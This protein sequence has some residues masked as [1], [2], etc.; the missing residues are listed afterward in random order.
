MPKSTYMYWNNRLDLPDKDLELRD[1]ILKI[2]EKHPCYGYRRITKVLNL[3]GILV[4]KKKVLRVMKKYNLKVTNFSNKSRK[5]NTYK[6]DKVKLGKNIINRKFYTTIPYQKITTDTTEFKYKEKVKGTNEYV[7]KKLYL[8][9]F[10]DM[11]NGE[12]ISYN[13]SKEHTTDG[14][15]NALSKAI[16]I[17]NSCKFQRIFHSDRGWAYSMKKYIKTLKKNKIRRS[18]S[19]KGNCYDNSPMENFFGILKQEIYY[20]KIFNSF[21]KLK[22]TIEEFIKYYNNERIKEKL[23][24]LSPVEYRLKYKKPEKKSV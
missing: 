13:I 17:T 2:Q 3:Q 14:I 15:M 4:N 6:A 9:P 19:R 22:T 8:D 10:L 24:Y 21:D 20:G 7:T 1:Q 23:G 16:A 5:L 12:I 11:F 18:L